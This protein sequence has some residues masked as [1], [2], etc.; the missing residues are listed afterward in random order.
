MSAI[1]NDYHDAGAYPSENGGT[2]HNTNLPHGYDVYLKL[3]VGMFA[4]D[5]LALSLFETP[6]DLEQFSMLLYPDFRSNFFGTWSDHM[7]SF[8]IKDLIGRSGD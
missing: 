7:Y 3:A 2:T 5:V 1:I 6:H 4:A 8:I